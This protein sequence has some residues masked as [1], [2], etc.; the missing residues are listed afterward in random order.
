MSPFKSKKRSWNGQEKETALNL[1]KEHINCG[2]LPSYPECV[3]AI[4]NNTDLKDRS[5]AQLK[6]WLSNQIQK[7]KIKTTISRGIFTL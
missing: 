2:E 3:Q 4:K 1:F 5:P 6:S 7:N